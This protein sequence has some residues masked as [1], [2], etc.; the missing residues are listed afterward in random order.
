MTEAQKKA[1]VTFRA[2]RS[3]NG[4]KQRTLWFSPED[5]SRLRAS[6][7]KANLTVTEFIRRQVRD[8]SV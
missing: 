5:D 1:Q 7:A 4:Y 8:A 6:A 2:K 3:Q